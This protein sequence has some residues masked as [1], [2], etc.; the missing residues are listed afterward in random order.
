MGKD[1][2]FE[3]CDLVRE[4]GFAIHQYHGYG[5]IEKIY[6]N[7]LFHRLTKQ[8]LQVEQ[9]IPLTVF[10]EDG[11]VLGDLE[12]DL[13][14]EGQLFIEVKAAKAENDAF[15]AQ[16]LGYL[17]AS[18]LEHGLLINF[19]APKFFIKKYVLAPIEPTSTEP[20]TRLE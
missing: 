11:T 4:T 6:E 1:R 17:R 9:R 7:A 3:L 10:D 16:L 13:L 20:P 15:T 18:R 12:A 14:V 8:G 5:H 19:G 2:V